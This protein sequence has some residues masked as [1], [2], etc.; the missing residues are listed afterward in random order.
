MAEPRSTLLPVRVYTDLDE[1]T[2]DDRQLRRHEGG[3]EG[4][5][6]LLRYAAV[7]SLADPLGDVELTALAAGRN[8]IAAAKAICRV[9]RTGLELIEARLPDLAGRGPL[10]WADRFH[11]DGVHPTVVI[12]EREAA[13][14]AAL[15]RVSFVWETWPDAGKLGDLQVIALVHQERR[16]LGICPRCALD[17]ESPPEEKG[18]CRR[19][20]EVGT[21]RVLEARTGRVLKVASVEASEPPPCTIDMRYRD[22]ESHIRDSWIEDWLK[23]TL[24]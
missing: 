8:G 16:L 11:G 15:P 6:D 23:L 7:H 1:V 12:R 21:I 18:R 19:V 14:R 17:A 22:A 20:R 10:P 13:W 5:I 9:S 2:I 4:T 24:R 3:F